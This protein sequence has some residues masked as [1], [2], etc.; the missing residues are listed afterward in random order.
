MENK[1]L[2]CLSMFWLHRVE[3]IIVITLYLK[4]SEQRDTM[5]LH[6]TSRIHKLSL[7]EV[8]TEIMYM[9]D[10]ITQSTLVIYT[11]YYAFLS[12]KIS[13]YSLQCYSFFHKAQVQ[14]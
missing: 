1:F 10:V 12:N 13:Q 8:L 5:E 7:M 11:V 3:R 4:C 2:N 6:F 9:P 14:F